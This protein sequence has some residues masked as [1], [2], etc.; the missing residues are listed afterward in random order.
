[1]PFEC[2]W[3]TM[4]CWDENQ[5]FAVRIPSNR[6]TERTLDCIAT[7]HCSKSYSSGQSQWNF[8]SFEFRF[9]VWC[10][11]NSALSCMCR[12]S[13]DQKIKRVLQ[14]V[15]IMIDLAVWNHWMVQPGMHVYQFD[16]TTSICKYKLIILR[17][18]VLHFQWMVPWNVW[19][20]YHV[21]MRNIIHR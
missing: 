20:N 7:V 4:N 12:K 8:L 6:I 18:I 11:S 21:W 14:P 3:S 2:R 16:F 5:W 1:M 10:K 15:T 19:K 9:G 17:T 13:N